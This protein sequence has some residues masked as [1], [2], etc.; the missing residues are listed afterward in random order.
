MKLD[1]EAVYR[2]RMYISRP[3]LCSKVGLIDWVDGLAAEVESLHAEL[4]RIN[5]E[6]YRKAVIDRM[7][8]QKAEVESLRAAVARV[9]EL[10]EAV[11]KDTPP[12]TLDPTVRVADVLDELD[13]PTP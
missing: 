4:D 13:G 12:A 5:S 10:C 6:P 2:A 11:Y 8:G 1:E 7:K 9:R 3:D